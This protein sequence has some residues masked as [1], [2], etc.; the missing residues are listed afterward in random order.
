MPDPRRNRWKTYAGVVVSVLLAALAGYVLWGTFQQISFADVLAQMAAVPASTLAIAAFCAASA[1]TVLAFYE[2]V[3]VRYVKGT[4]GRAKPMLTAFIA[5]PLGHAVGQAMLSGGALR[6]RMY[7]PAGFSATEVGAT[8]LLANMPYALGFGLL[9]DVSLV[10]ASDMLAPMFRVSA[11]WLFV[12]GCIGLCKDVGYVLLILYRKRPIKLG[13]W[14]VNLPSPALTALQVAVGLADIFLVSSVLYLL[15]P[16]T[17]GIGYLAFLGAYL[18][19]VLVGVLSHVPA[20]LGVLES[21][22]LLLLP[23]VPPEQLLAAVLMY[24]VIY[25]IIPVLLA[26]LL[27]FAFESFSR[28]GA[29]LRA[30]RRQ[31]PIVRPERP[32]IDSN[33]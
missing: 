2:V 29:L 19:S 9:L 6:Y 21:M 22:L 16:D 8:A 3:V 13:G 33:E 31:A 24:R 23:G 20:G 1:F 25:E 15:L 10:F 27:W 11:D 26:L 30:L 28:D 5:F 32:T 14:A 12:L 17:I 18:A 7:A 4:V